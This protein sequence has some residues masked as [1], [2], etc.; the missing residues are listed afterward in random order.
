MLGI[1]LALY[2]IY[3]RPEPPENTKYAFV[4]IADGFNRPTYV[5]HAYNDRLFVVEQDGRIW[6]LENGQKLD[7]PFLDI[8][9]IV[10]SE[11]NEQ[12]LFSV[13]FPPDYA[14]TGYFYIAYTRTEDGHFQVMRY[15]V[16]QQSPNQ[17]DPESATDILFVEQPSSRHNGGLL[18][19]GLDGYLYLG[20]GD[21][22]L[23]RDED[24]NGQNLNTLLGA[25]LRIDVSD[26]NVPYN[27]P[28]DN[29]FINSDDARPEIWAYGLRN[30]WRYSFDPQTGDIWIGD[31]GQSSFEEVNF[32]AGDSSGGENYGW[33]IFEGSER[34]TYTDQQPT[35]DMIMPVNSYD[36]NRIQDG[37][38]GEVKFCSVIGGYVYRGETLTD[39]Q[40]QYLFGDWCTGVV[41]TMASPESE[42]EIF[43]ETPFSFSSFGVDVNGELYLVS[44]D[45]GIWQLQENTTQ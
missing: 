30:P 9:D 17:A 39:L 21:G 25:L 3:E 29:P 5:T 42:P 18:K 32:Q 11:N 26:P 12:G 15:R 8:Q 36:H 1:V 24:S 19:F 33:P 23:A 7:P 35:D 37:L 31:V 38:F 14:T 27:I 44:Y 34:T 22:S 28:P 10:G 16:D 40:G 6:I 13:A 20:L 4:Q 2:I 45:G 43:L 41:W